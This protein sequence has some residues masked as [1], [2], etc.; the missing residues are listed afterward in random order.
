[1]K[2]K[3]ENACGHAIF[4]CSNY[5]AKF[6]FAISYDISQRSDSGGNLDLAHRF[7]ENE[8]FPG[9]VGRGSFTVVSICQLHRAHGDAT[10]HPH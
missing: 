6:F 1:M 3:K 2:M 8:I 9:W 4:S 7:T 10:C 5:C